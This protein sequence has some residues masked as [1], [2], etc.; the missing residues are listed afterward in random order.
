M[1]DFSNYI[2]LF[3]TYVSA[4][5]KNC[6]SEI[7]LKNLSLKFNH[8]KNVLFHCEKI[9]ESENLNPENVFIAQL[10]GLFH[11]IGRF[12]QFTKYNT[13][14]DDNSVYHGALGVEVLLK[15]KFIADL[16][17]RIQTIVNT[18]V[19]NHGLLSI[20]P[21]VTGDEL[22]FSKLVRDADKADIFAIVAKYY[23]TAGPRN[24]ALEY[25]LQDIP[26]ISENV[27]FKFCSK[28]MISKDELRTLNDFKLMQLAW[29]FDINFRYTKQFIQKNN[30]TEAV[31][32]SITDNSSKD[33][34]NSLI[35]EVMKT[36]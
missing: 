5:T 6:D 9:A 12:E 23:H 26:I 33:I 15:E 36:D 22:Y 4:F 35:S 24:I 10:C 29:I 16:P 34:I 2:K 13:F 7:T 27:L 8:S 21:N 11:D 30:Y 19:Y 31:L 32:S 17:Q 3:D 1:F 25:G 18:A 28:E 14:K 20:S